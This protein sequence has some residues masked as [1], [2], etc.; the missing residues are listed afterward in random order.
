ML[1][2]VLLKG[3]RRGVFLMSE[4][5][6]Y[7]PTVF[8]RAPISREEQEKRG[9][10]GEQ[11]EISFPA[12]VQGVWCRVSGLEVGMLPMGLTRTSRA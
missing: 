2:I 1:V 5:P 3:P 8:R 6:M 10:K 9:G 11:L 4:V 12:R 7:G